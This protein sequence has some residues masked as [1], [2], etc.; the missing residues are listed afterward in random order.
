MYNSLE[1]QWGQVCPTSHT[2]Y[3]GV[4]VVSIGFNNPRF[5]VVNVVRCQNN[6]PGSVAHKIIMVIISK[7][8]EWSGNIVQNAR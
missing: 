2:E 8:T 6:I 4:S 5:E 1:S 3:S 7:F